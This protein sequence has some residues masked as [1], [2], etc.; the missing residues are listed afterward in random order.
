[1]GR[2]LIS[3]CARVRALADTRFARAPMR[4]PVL[5]CHYTLETAHMMNEDEAL[6]FFDWFVMDH[7]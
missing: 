7:T 5:G 2:T 3:R 1:M 6:R 4:W